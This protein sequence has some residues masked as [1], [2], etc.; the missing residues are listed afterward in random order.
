MGRRKRRV[1][2]PMTNHK[3]KE[4]TLKKTIGFIFMIAAATSYANDSNDAGEQ[5]TKSLVKIEQG[6]LKLEKQLLESNGVDVSKLDPKRFC[7]HKGLPSSVGYILE[8]GDIKLVCKNIKNGLSDYSGD[9]Q[10]VK[11]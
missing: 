9:A 5:A 2:R 11:I 1:V 10:W 4:K 8:E 3:C 6:L 7:V